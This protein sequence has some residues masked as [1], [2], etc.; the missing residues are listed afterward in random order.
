M[1]SI[2]QSMHRIIDENLA[3]DTTNKTITC[4]LLHPEICSGNCNYN[5]NSKVF[6]QIVNKYV[7]ND[8]D[9]ADFYYDVLIFYCNVE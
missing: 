5:V 3:I 6:S 4:V 9:Y 7:L 8:N 2:F 1:L